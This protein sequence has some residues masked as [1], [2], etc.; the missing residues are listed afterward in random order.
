MKKYTSLSRAPNVAINS[1]P[2]QV[3]SLPPIN[4]KQGH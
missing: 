2:S 4:M 3:P 1:K